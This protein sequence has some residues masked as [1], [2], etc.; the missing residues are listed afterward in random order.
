MQ[1]NRCLVCT[2]VYTPPHKRSHSLLPR[3]NTQFLQAV[4]CKS[5]DT[6]FCLRIPSL[7][8]PLS[9]LSPLYPRPTFTSH[10]CKSHCHFHSQC[11]LLMTGPVVVCRRV[12]ASRPWQFLTDLTGHFR[13]SSCSLRC[14]CWFLVRVVSLEKSATGKIS[15]RAVM[16]AD[17]GHSLPAASRA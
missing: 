3:L 8:I 2:C 12:S 16:D 7:P 13:T 15:H 11:S 5:P 17:L 4:S 14:P 1:L 6:F 9:Q 10:L